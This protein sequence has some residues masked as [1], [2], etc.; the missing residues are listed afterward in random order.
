MNGPSR[1]RPPAI[2]APRRILSGIDNPAQMLRI[3]LRVAPQGKPSTAQ[4][5]ILC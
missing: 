1:W 4:Y 2:A 5:P 3:F